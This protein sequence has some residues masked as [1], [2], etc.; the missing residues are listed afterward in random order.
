MNIIKEIPSKETYIVRQPVLRKGKPI[1]SCIFEGDDLE[2]THHFGLFQNKNLTGIISLFTKSNPIFAENLQGQIR[3][4]AIL[5]NHQKKGF[6]EALVKHCE[7][8]CRQNKVD[9]IWFN[10]RTAAV[11]FY[12]RMNYEVLGEPFE[13]KDVGEHYLMFKKI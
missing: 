6:G 1:E 10:A 2:T 4:M 9:L 11:G 8:Y 3:G 7:D 12:K 5:E 13:I